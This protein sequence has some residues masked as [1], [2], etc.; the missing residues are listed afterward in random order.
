MGQNKQGANSV[1]LIQ[2]SVTFTTTLYEKKHRLR[3]RFRIREIKGTSES[4]LL[5]RITLNGVRCKSDFSTGIKIQTDTWNS[6]TQTVKGKNSKVINDQLDTF[7]MDLINNFDY[8]KESGRAFG[9]DCLRKSYTDDVPKKY[10]LVDIGQMLLDRKIQKF[11]LEK[12]SAKT[13]SKARE[14]QKNLEWIFEKTKWDWPL[15]SITTKQLEQLEIWLRNYTDWHWNTV[16]K[17]LN[18]MKEVIKFGMAEGLIPA[19]PIVLRVTFIE[20]EHHALTADQVRVISKKKWKNPDIEKAADCFLFQCYTG[21]AY[22]DLKQFDSR[23]HL[24]VNNLEE[25]IQLKR[26][27]SP[28]EGKAYIAKVPLLPAAKRIL[29]KYNYQ[30]PVLSNQN[31]NPYL[32][33]IGEFL[34]LDWKLTSH[35]ARKTFCTILYN[36]GMS[37]HM[38]GEW[39]G[40]STAKTTLAS[41]A[42]GEVVAMGASVKSL[43]YG[44]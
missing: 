2:N 16:S 13:I 6:K 40:H 34:Q 39:V 30:L 12:R 23:I 26:T 22:G 10:T 19:R 38:I 5:C 41:Y 28:R 15:E 1:T 17:I 33:M 14:R 24:K 36:A 43:G 20:T 32:H 31:Y 9:P 11:D 21:L 25:M 42:K 7:R 4:Y 44:T 18:F 8:L 27:K 29:E 35:H 3:I 37:I